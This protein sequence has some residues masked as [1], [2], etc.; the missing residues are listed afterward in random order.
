MTDMR[1][2]I[3]EDIISKLVNCHYISDLRSIVDKGN[4]RDLINVIREI[5]S[6][7]YS[8]NQWCELNNYLFSVNK[9]YETSKD[10]YDDL[11]KMLEK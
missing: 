3:F 6:Q 9:K 8:V 10:V 2:D 1:T 11:L 4:T 5:D 7:D